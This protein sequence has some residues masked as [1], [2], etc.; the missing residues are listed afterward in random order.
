[1]LI[2]IK[3]KYTI[4]DLNECNKLV[5]MYV[6][7]GSDNLGTAIKIYLGKIYLDNLWE[8]INKCF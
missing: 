8:L 7:Q 4:I 6:R 1:M 5:Y 2:L 3:E